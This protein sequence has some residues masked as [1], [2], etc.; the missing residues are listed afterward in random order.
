MT[1]IG[2]KVKATAGSDM[3]GGTIVGTGFRQSPEPNGDHGFMLLVLTED[4]TFE[5]CWAVNYE[6]VG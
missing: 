3:T 1:L 4:G 2:K 5:E 6:V